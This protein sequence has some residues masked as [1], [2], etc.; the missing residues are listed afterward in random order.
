MGVCDSI[1]VSVCVFVCA[2][3]IGFVLP[4]LYTMFVQIGLMLAA[5]SQCLAL[6]FLRSTKATNKHAFN[7]FSIKM[8]SFAYACVRVCVAFFSSRKC[9]ICSSNY[10]AGHRWLCKHTSRDS[11]SKFRFLRFIRFLLFVALVY[12]IPI[13]FHIQIRMCQSIVSAILS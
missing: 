11:L 12:A 6:S 1:S 3:T 9:E 8:F 13:L 2:R 4:R 7:S 5:S 10:V